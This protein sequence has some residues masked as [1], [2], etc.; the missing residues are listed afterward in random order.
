MSQ[1]Q[2]F[3]LPPSLG[4]EPFSRPCCILIMKCIHRY[5]CLYLVQDH[6]TLRDLG[7]RNG[8]V[9]TLHPLGMPA[10]QKRKLANEALRNKQPAA[11][12]ED[13]T[14]I[15]NLSTPIPA[16]RAVC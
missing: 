7:I 8:S 2:R 15:L 4:E 14:P 11:A 16:H 9:L 3:E 6:I 12:D 10:E 5:K 1:K 13:E